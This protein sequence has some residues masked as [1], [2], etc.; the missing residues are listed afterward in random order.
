MNFTPTLTSE[1]LRGKVALVTGGA[2]GIGRA[3][4]ETLAANGASVCIADVDPARAEAAKAEIG[5]DT[6]IFAGDLVDPAV[7]DALIEH[8]IRTHGQLDIIVNGA[9]YSWD[10]PVHR[11]SDDQFQAMLDIHLLAPFRI[12]R[13]AAPHFRDSAA[14]GSGRT[15]AR[16]VVN[17]ASLSASWG[18]HGAA[19][20]AAAKAG[21][22]GL[23][24]TL[25]SEWGRFNVTVNAVSFGIIQTR[26]GAPLSSN[27][28]IKTGGREIPLGIPDKTLTALGLDTNSPDIFAA[29]PLQRATLGRT[30]TIQEAA[31]AIFWLASPLSDYVTGQVI[32]VSGGSRGG[33]D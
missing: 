24:R 25:A 9:G 21:L 17:V 13:A 7:P 12:L 28:T 29:Q 6:S 18:N 23:T 2:Q 33:F 14:N 8:V 16:K 31:D 1:L 3:T 5:G 10:A 32:A 27:E 15:H 22:V 11:M 19:N 30:G 4:A 20:Y 26:L